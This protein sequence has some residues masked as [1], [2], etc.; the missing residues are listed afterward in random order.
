MKVIDGTAFGA[1]VIC[2]V[3]CIAGIYKLSEKELSPDTIETKAPLKCDTTITIKNGK[4]D[5]LYIYHL[6][7]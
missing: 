7:K 4:A 2:I 1:I 5:T 6:P 3:L